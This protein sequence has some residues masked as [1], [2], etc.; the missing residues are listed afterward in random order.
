MVVINFTEFGPVAP[1]IVGSEVLAEVLASATDIIDSTP[2]AVLD[3]ILDEWT[4]AL[5]WRAFDPA[6][7]DTDWYLR[8]L[9][10]VCMR[11][12]RGE[13]APKFHWIK[14]L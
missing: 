4:T 12:L 2:E 3:E 9:L 8:A 5:T 7:V 14:D 11:G 10:C 1:H 13:I 6:P